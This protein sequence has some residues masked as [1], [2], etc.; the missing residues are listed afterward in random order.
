MS[1]IVY[2]KGDLLESD[3]SIII[4]G[5]NIKG[6]FGSGVAGAIKNRYPKCRQT[7]LAAFNNG[8][9][10]MGG[11]VPYY[12]EVDNRLI[13]NAITQPEYGYD[14]QKYVD[15]DA[16]RTAMILADE[17]IGVGQRLAMPKIGA[18]LGGGDWNIISEIIE[19]C[20]INNTPI[21]YVID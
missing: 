3:E 13:L 12:D 16:I 15:Y 9:L 21:V 7:Y 2:I 17:T 5:C 18:G 14:G 1:K 8:E 20:V 6:G 19:Q 11:I 10:T 4:H